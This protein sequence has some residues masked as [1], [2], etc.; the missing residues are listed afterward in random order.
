MQKFIYFWHVYLQAS[1]ISFT[2]KY[3]REYSHATVGSYWFLDQ[4]TLTFKHLPKCETPPGMVSYS[5]PSSGVV[6]KIN[7]PWGWFQKWS[8]PSVW[9]QKWNPSCAMVST[10]EFFPRCGRKSK[11]LLWSRFKSENLLRV[12]SKSET[13]PKWKPLGRCSKTHHAE[14]RSYWCP[15]STTHLYRNLIRYSKERSYVGKK[16]HLTH[17]THPRHQPVLLYLVLRRDVTCH[18]LHAQPAKSANTI[19]L[20]W[21]VIKRNL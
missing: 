11:I 14:H 15:M 18:L 4:S 7:L 13:L 2:T 12:V 10:R 20:W 17:A 16:L 5:R 6:L 21:K 19:W 9:F 3:A 8:G 1:H